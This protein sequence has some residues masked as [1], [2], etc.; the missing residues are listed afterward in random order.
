MMQH[1]DIFKNIALSFIVHLIQSSYFTVLPCKKRDDILLNNY[2]LY[3]RA[4]QYWA[5]KKKEKNF[6]KNFYKKKAGK[7]KSNCIMQ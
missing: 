1:C 5:G 7:E 6:D 3:N 2:K 4:R